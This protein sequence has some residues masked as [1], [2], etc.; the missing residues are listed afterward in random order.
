MPKKPAIKFNMI[1]DDHSRK[2]TRRAAILATEMKK[3][4]AIRPTLYGYAMNPTFA[5]SFENDISVDM[6][7]LEFP[8]LTEESQIEDV[9]KIIEINEGDVIEVMEFI[10]EGTDG[11][12]DNP[13]TRMLVN[14]SKMV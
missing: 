10:Y 3:N 7:V 9:T 5:G 11:E 2:I 6:F 8:K 14:S 1:E 13:V 4:N 12:P